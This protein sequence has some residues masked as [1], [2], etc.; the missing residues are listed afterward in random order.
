MDQ[1]KKNRKR[2]NISNENENTAKKRK[3]DKKLQVSFIPDEDNIIMDRVKKNLKRKKKT[4]KYYQCKIC[5]LTS[6]MNNKI[7][8]HLKAKHKLNADKY[9]TTLYI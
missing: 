4:I 6:K 8:K 7:R 2:K 3:I 5:S 1:V 9:I